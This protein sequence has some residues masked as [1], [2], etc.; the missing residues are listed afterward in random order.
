MAFEVQHVEFIKLKFRQ[1]YWGKLLEGVFIF[2]STFCHFASLYDVNATVKDMCNYPGPGTGN[3]SVH[4]IWTAAS[5]EVSSSQKPSLKVRAEST[6]SFMRV[7][8]P[9]EK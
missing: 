7:Q 8:C 3:F 2:K 5:V 4:E 9:S 6:D 1:Q